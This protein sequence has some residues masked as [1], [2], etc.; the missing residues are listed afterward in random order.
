ML[1]DAKLLKFT[2]TNMQISEYFCNSLKN[3]TTM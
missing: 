3:L 1:Y 2:E